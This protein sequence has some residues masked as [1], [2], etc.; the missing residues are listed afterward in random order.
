MYIIFYSRI[1][2]FQKE[3]SGPFTDIT[4]TNNF[5]HQINLFE[6]GSFH[7]HYADKKF[8]EIL[9]SKG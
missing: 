1:A 7:F 2:N 6:T 4:L 9:T 5:S 3:K 8:C